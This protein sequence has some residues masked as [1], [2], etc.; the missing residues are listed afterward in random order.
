MLKLRLSTFVAA[1]LFVAF[2][3]QSDTENPQPATG[4][5]ADQ[6]TNTEEATKIS[7]YRLDGEVVP[8]GAYQMEDPELQFAIT[9]Q[10]N[11]E[12]TAQSLVV[13][14]FTND[15]AYIQWGDKN[16]YD[17]ASTLEYE[18][19]VAKFAEESGAIRQYEETGEVSQEFL[20]FQD[21][22]Y[23]RIF[24]TKA[25]VYERSMGSGYLSK[26]CSGGSYRRMSS[27]RAWMWWGWNNAV[28]NY[29]Q[30]GGLRY[31]AI[32]N[33]TFFRSRI[34]TIYGWGSYSINFCGYSWLNDRMSSYWTVGW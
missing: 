9:L 34:A 29:Y 8:E 10:P 31:T 15:D 24:Q 20:E 14:A 17:V 7:E 27:V 22:E 30:S 25:L 21:A 6:T 13:D 5:P 28:S 26:N 4:V 16:G 11:E 33:R 18:R 19:N 12:G 3:C 32:Y 1:I 23:E 2:G